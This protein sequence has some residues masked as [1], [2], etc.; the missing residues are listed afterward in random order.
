M[1]LQSPARI[2]ILRVNLKEIICQIDKLPGIWADRRF[3]LASVL[4]SRARLGLGDAP[5]PQW[6]LTVCGERQ[7]A[8]ADLMH[9]YAA[10]QEAIA[11]HGPS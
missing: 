7:S 8:Q 11:E 10:L 1:N 6:A 9:V 3:L 5:W 2:S 4:D